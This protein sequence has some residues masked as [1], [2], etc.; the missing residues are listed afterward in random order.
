MIL[1]HTYFKGG[2]YLPCLVKESSTV[3]VSSM[4]QTVAEGSLDWFIE[5][6]ESEFFIKL[7]GDKFYEDFSSDT[8]DKFKPI[9]DALFKKRHTYSF[10]PVANYVYFMVKRNQRTQTTTQGERVGVESYANTAFDI[11]KLISAWNGMCDML[12]QFRSDFVCD[13]WTPYREYGKPC[14]KWVCKINKLGI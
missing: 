9:R 8:T 13:R 3:G 10:S 6:Y 12:E 1:D 11:D 14:F 5:R 7:F 4:M 2:L